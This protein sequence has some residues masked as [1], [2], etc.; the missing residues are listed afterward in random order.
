MEII[1]GVVLVLGGRFM[2]FMVMKEVGFRL[3]N[4]LREG[5]GV[6]GKGVEMMKGGGVVKDGMWGVCV[7]VGVMFGRGGLG[8]IVMGL[9]RV[10]DGGEGGKRVL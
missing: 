3:K 2:G 7:G 1:K 5:M 9:F 8:E 4:V 10:R 6:E